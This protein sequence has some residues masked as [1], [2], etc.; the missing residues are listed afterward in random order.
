MMTKNIRQK[1]F[2]CDSRQDVDEL[3][4]IYYY[5]NYDEIYAAFSLARQYGTKMIF[6]G[7]RTFEIHPIG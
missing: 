2:F 5:K 1:P 4:L 6:E 3:K 7:N